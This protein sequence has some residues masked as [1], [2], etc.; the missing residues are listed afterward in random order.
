MNHL[1][2]ISYCLAF[3]LISLGTAAQDTSRISISPFS[4]TKLIN[5]KLCISSITITGN[6]KTKTYIIQRELQFKKGDSL[7][8]PSLMKDMEQARSQ[9]YNTS[10][11]NEVRI[12]VVS[13]SESDISITIIV[14]ERWHVYPVPQFQWVDR[15]FNEWWKTYKHSLDRVNY[16]IKFAHYNLTGRRDQLRVYFIN[17]YSRNY[18]VSY[19]N[20]SINKKLNRG[21]SFTFNHFQNREIAYKSSLNNV[22][23]FYP[24]TPD[25][26][27][28]VTGDFVRTG[29]YVAGGYSIRNGLFTRHSISA[30][31][32]HLKIED[33][34]I[35]KK[36][37]PN[38]F[39]DSV[40]VKNFIDLAYTFQYNRLD[41]NSYPLEGISAYAA[42]LK[43]GLGITGGLNMLSL[44]GGL[45]KYYNLKKNWYAHV[46]L[47]A[48][49]KLPFDQSYLNQRG[50]GYGETY[51]RGL[52]YKVIDGVAYGLVKGTLRKK[53]FHFSIPFPFF[54]KVLTKIP[55]TFY[56]KTYA[57]A[58]YVYTK[59]K[60][61]TYLSNR[62]L[63][64]GG[65]GIDVLSVYDVN[66]RFEYSFNQLGQR[67][68]FF[69]TQN[70]F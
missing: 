19:S 18:I 41:N 8:A 39:K 68:L 37:N 26:S 28:K 55:F 31:F 21:I 17:G 61:D 13:V 50:L 4:L 7:Y 11:F 38:Y 47:Y 44:E 67:G 23:Q 58:G 43:R 52:E 34:V 10:L 30:G 24:V 60:Y 2:Q 54:P 46:Q 48:K 32:T 20:P 69:H 15:N 53:L 22:L 51:L 56:A 36:Y 5:K 62:F 6:R 3:L 42:I 70:G 12:N 63:Y 45:T 33:S 35:D 49:V 64:T 16:G 59:K 25:S 65:F 40:T 1:K 14:K 57:D 27:I 9:V 29:Y 66:L